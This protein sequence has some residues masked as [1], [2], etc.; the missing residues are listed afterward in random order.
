MNFIEAMEI[1]RAVSAL[2]AKSSEKPPKFR[3]YDNQNEGYVILAK[4]HLINAE[5]RN[6][7]ET[8]ADSCNLNIR[9]SEGYLIIYGS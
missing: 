5:Y 1:L 7:I 8:I 6:Q 3:I 2:Q 9:E 4:A